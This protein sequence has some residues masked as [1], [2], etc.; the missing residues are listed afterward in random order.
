MSTSRATRTAVVAASIVVGLG[1]VVYYASG[2]PQY[3]LFQL[4]RA[5]QRGDSA[6]MMRFIDV[7]GLA[8]STMAVQL[9]TLQASESDD[10]REQMQASI[11]A[12]Q[13]QLQSVM[14]QRVISERIRSSLAKVGGGAP[15][16]AA[17][18]I[19]LRS[20]TRTGDVAR[21]EL[22]REGDE[23]SVVDFDM[24]R[25]PDR[26]WKVVRADMQQ[27]GAILQ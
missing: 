26:T 5:M 15:A 7:D 10:P 8:R 17:P 12:R 25:Q 3:S 22:A 4:G 2:T 1:A 9:E 19:D 21:V 6:E 13:L 24:Q 11:Q 27:L 20:V 16:A 23:E 14:I 18:A